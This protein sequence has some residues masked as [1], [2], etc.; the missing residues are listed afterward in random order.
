MAKVGAPE[1][2]ID[3]TKRLDGRT[4]N[5]MRPIETDVGV[6]KKAT[7]SGIFRFGS[8]HALSAVYGP[9][10]FHPRFLQDPQKAVLKCRYNMA[11]FSTGDRIRPGYNRRSTEI[12][13]VIRQAL[14]SVVCVED[15]P[16]TG[17][18]IYAEIMQA[19]ASTR[20]AGLNAASLALAD[21]GVPMRELVCSCSVG[22]VEDIIIMDLDGPEDM[23]GQVDLAVATIGNQDKFVLLQM[24]GVV[25]KDEFMK[26]IELSKKGC[27]TVYEAQKKI[28]REKYKTGETNDK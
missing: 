13:K 28:L 21:A 5:D 4:L 8:T 12:S 25:T 10:P 11:P 26:M 1:K 18:E 16:R 22:K 15:Y 7:G 17:I 23:F 6:I 19:N 24:D 27:G 20:C 3:G 9:K 14:N 2:M